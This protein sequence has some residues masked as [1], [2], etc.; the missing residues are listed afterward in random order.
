ML[1]TKNL[2]SVGRV[3]IDSLFFHLGNGRF[4]DGKKGKASSHDTENTTSNVELTVEKLFGKGNG[5]LGEIDPRADST[6]NESCRDNV[7]L[8]SDIGK[9]DGKLENHERRSNQTANHGECVLQSHNGSK[10]KRKR[11]I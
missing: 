9:V 7:L 3:S 6:T 10:D 4:K 1:H 5:S 11:F 8:G 2:R